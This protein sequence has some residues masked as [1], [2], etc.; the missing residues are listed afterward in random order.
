MV[1]LKYADGTEFNYVSPS[2]R[3][4]PTPAD[5]LE[6]RDTETAR[7]WLPTSVSGTVEIDLKGDVRI[8]DLEGSREFRKWLEKEVENWKFTPASIDGKPVSVRLP[9]LLLLG[10]TTH[11]LTIVE[12][13]RRR[14]IRGPLFVWPGFD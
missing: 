4:S 14:G 11:N 12:S 1:Q 2:L 10:K 6:I 5:H 8:V 9:F 3:V 7:G 13:M